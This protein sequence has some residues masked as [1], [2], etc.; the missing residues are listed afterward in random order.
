M[1]YISRDGNSFSTFKI[2]FYTVIILF[3]FEGKTT[4]IDFTADLHFD[5]DCI[6]VR[7]RL[8]YAKSAKSREGP[9]L[10][11]NPNE[12]GEPRGQRQKRVQTGQMFLNFEKKT[13]QDY[14]LKFVTYSL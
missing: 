14:L 4:S 6:G 7:I 1:L 13:P 9:T 10:Q 8:L 12:D 5:D 11:E 2:A 3:N